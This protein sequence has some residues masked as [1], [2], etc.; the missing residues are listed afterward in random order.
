MKNKKTLTILLVVMMLAVLAVPVIVMADDFTGSIYISDSDPPVIDS[1]TVTNVAP[2]IRSSDCSIS[3]TVSDPQ[4]IADIAEIMLVFWHSTTPGDPTDLPSFVQADNDS[5]QLNWIVVWGTSETFQP[6]S[7]NTTWAA[8][9]PTDPTPTA[10][11][12]TFDFTVTVGKEAMEVAAPSDTDK[13]L[14][15]VKVTD[16]SNNTA[17]A[18][19]N[20]ATGMQLE[21][22]WYGEMTASEYAGPFWDLG[23]PGMSYADQATQVFTGSDTLFVLANGDYRIQTYA[24]NEWINSETTPTSIF[25]DTAVDGDEEFSIA[26]DTTS[27]Y[28][29]GTAQVLPN[30]TG[31]LNHTDPINI[32]PSGAWGTATDINGV[33]I[34]DIYMFLQTSTNITT[35]DTPYTGI[36][37]FSVVNDN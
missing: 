4:T 26:V 22:E 29:V 23:S 17:F 27:T 5:T 11:S 21:M 20:G 24:D 30:D 7:T 36:V 19:A 18:L 1:F 8:T 9:S 31:A 37:V 12:A 2:L 14:I 10:T 13:W 6:D 25:Y 33:T 34:T 32:N 3:L 16:T 28:N 15:G 35:S